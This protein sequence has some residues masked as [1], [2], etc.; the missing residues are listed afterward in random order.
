MF[1]TILVPL[2]GTRFAEAVLPGAV[3][4]ARR[5]RGRLHLL[6]AHQP[7]SPMPTRAAVG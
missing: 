4:L 3:R 5:A 7:T 1:D 2:D 6:L